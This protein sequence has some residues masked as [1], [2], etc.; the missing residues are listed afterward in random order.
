MADDHAVDH[1]GPSWSE[2][3]ATLF[4][5]LERWRQAHPRATFAEIEAAVE[6]RLGLLRAEL[7]AQELALRAAAEAAETAAAS[8][9]GTAGAEGT[10]QA[11]R[12]PTCGGPTQARGTRER[13]LTVRGNRPVR[14]RRRY[15]V[16]PACGTGH[17]PP[18]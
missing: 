2:M 17:F 10:T 6:E 7:I 12:C 18:R 8:A 9:A 3:E 14:L 5:D 13:S 4:A 11:V 16:C 15:V 1:V